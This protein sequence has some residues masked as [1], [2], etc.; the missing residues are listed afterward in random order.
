M[1]I[2]EK[3]SGKKSDASEDVGGVVKLDGRIRLR[4]AAAE[5]AKANECVAELEARF[6]RLQNIISDADAAHAALQEAIA[7]D[8]GLAL[9]AY[10][11]GLASD[12][13]I[14]ELV[15]IKENTSK[16]ASAAKD[17]L[18][19]VEDMLARARAEAARLENAKFDA[20]I[21]Y[22]KTCARGEHRRYNDA[23]AELSRSYDA[24][25]GIAVAVSATGHA[26]MMTTGLPVPIKAPG[27]NMSTG[28]SHGPSELVTLTHNITEARIAGSTS[29]WMQ[30]RERLWQDPDADLDD[31]IGPQS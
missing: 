5:L 31:L 10:G 16:A 18:P 9:E 19:S 21:V 14:A 2:L 6:N 26:D 29:T 1:G 24:L 28:P 8:G 7:A 11:A 4:K 20:T 23:F 15:A 17:A 12:Q 25:C 13:P 30:A 3:I 27:F 22:L